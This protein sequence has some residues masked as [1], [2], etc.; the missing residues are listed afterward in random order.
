[1]KPVLAALA[2]IHRHSG[3]HRDVKVPARC[4]MHQLM[5]LGPDCTWPR[6]SMWCMGEAKACR[7]A[8]LAWTAWL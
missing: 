2:Y 6:T 1:M 5:I 3:I 4:C 8:G 7:R